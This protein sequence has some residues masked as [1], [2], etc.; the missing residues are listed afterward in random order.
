MSEIIELHKGIAALNEA[1]KSQAKATADNQE[2][3][4]KLNTTMTD[5][6]V[7]MREGRIK[8]D[9]IEER[10]EVVEEYLPNLAKLKL[11]QSR[12]DDFIKGMFGSW[13]RLASIAIVVALF[14]AL[15]L[16]TDIFK[17]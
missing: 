5:V 9:H 12:W 10:V 2:A 8:S 7:E 4:T 3:M 15:G 17:L 6:L 14:L 11:S 1:V 16:N 13:G